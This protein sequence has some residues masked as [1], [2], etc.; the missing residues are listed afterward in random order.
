MQKQKSKVAAAREEMRQLRKI[1]FLRKD[2]ISFVIG[3]YSD[4]SIRFLYNVCVA[5]ANPGV[6]RL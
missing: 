2:H 1:K 6:D 4:L 3:H 5:D